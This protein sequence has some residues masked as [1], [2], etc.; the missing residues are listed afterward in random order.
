VTSVRT[1]GGNGFVASLR[2]GTP[3]RSIW[4]G[5]YASHR[6]GTDADF[7][8][9]TPRPSADFGRHGPLHDDRDGP[10]GEPPEDGPSGESEGR[11]VRRDGGGQA[12]RHGGAGPSR[13]RLPPGS[14]VRSGADDQSVRPPGPDWTPRGATAV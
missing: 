3:Q 13:E 11:D 10:A 1:A 6:G 14:G 7:G 9:Q 4:P 8:R 2:P 5:S 12:R